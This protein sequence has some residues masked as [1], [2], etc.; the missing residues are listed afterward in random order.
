ML[1]THARYAY[2][3][4]TK[5]PEYAW[6]G[7]KRLAVYV[8]LNIEAFS[9]GSG[10][11]AAI[12]P[13][14]QAAS[15]SIF[16]WRDYGNRVGMWRLFELFDELDIPI[17]AQMNTAIY[18]MAPDIP[19]RLRARG[20][21][22]L[23]HGE[24]NSD[25]QGHLRESEE[26]ALIERV[27]AAIALREG[28]PP[29]GWM[30]PWLS[31]S[32]VTPDLLQEAGYRYFMDWTMDDQPV[33]LKTRAGRILAMPYPIEVNDN[34]A[35]V[36]YRHT[37]EEFADLIVDQFDEMLAQSRRQPLVCPISLH[38]FII[39]R[40]YRIRH[41]RRALQHILQHRNEIWLTRPR[42]ICAHVESLA[43]GVLPGG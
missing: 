23:G 38:P 7:G 15:H 21:E 29:V 22:I 40:P 43:P 5:R 36:W 10:K 17:E 1:P 12:A 35:I 8:A 39:G 33:W 37:S 28:K 20:D 18:E 14:E 16:S 3:N 34:R 41:L 19:E 32:G 26:R 30:S 2:S 13:P 11:G 4:I 24:T 42:D 27:T 6:P 31:N 25:E 9:F